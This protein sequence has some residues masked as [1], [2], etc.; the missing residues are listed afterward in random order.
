MFPNKGCS[1]I[2]VTCPLVYFHDIISQP[3]GHPFLNVDD[4]KKYFI[5]VG[6]I[7]KEI[8]NKLFLEVIF[9]VVTFI[10]F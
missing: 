8:G 7:F 9:V 5:I 6:E 1:C 4:V 10:I 3:D 2:T